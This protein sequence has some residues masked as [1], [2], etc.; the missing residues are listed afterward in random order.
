MKILQIP[1]KPRARLNLVDP[2]TAP[3]P[4]L[5]KKLKPCPAPVSEKKIQTWPW[6]RPRLF[7]KIQTRPR[8]RYFFQP[9]SVLLQ[10]CIRKVSSKSHCKWIK[11]AFLKKCCQKRYFFKF[12][13]FH[14]EFRPRNIRRLT[15]S[16]QFFLPR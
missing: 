2:G 1:V 13:N 7:K 14:L 10:F 16:P 8:P 6:S 12:W 9:R 3:A 11:N 15:I 4:V 5:K